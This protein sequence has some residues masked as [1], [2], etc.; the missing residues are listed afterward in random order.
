M[1]TKP[2]GRLKKVDLRSYWKR[3]DTHFTP[4]G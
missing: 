2:L 4:Y 1:N 3:E